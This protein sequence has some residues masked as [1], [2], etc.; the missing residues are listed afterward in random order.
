MHGLVVLEV[1]GHASF[2]GDHQAEIFHMAMRSLLE[3]V[4]RR[5][6]ECAGTPP[7]AG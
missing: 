6:P 5:I 7:M 1:F 2:V 4:H 3:D